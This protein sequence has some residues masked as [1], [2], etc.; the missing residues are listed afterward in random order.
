M[1]G[2]LVETAGCRYVVPLAQGGKNAWALNGGLDVSPL[3]GSARSV[4]VRGDLVPTIALR[5]SSA[6]RGNPLLDR[7]CSYTRHA[8]P[9]RIVLVWDRRQTPW[10]RVQ[11]VIQRTLGEG[12][13]W[14]LNRIFRGP[15]SLG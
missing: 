11:A 9:T 3:E 15:R 10:A 4:A 7:N 5:N 6:P 1:M 13:V 2:L 8:W 14:E 12:L